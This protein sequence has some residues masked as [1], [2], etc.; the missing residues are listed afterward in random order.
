MFKLIPVSDRPVSNQT[1]VRDILFFHIVTAVTPI[2]SNGVIQ[3]NGV[4]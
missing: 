2:M 1:T 3:S 4:D